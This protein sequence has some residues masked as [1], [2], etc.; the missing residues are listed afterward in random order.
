MSS[1]PPLTLES[2]RI[3]LLAAIGEVRRHLEVRLGRA[4]AAEPVEEANPKKTK[5]NAKVPAAEKAP[6]EPALQGPLALVVERFSLSPFERDVLLL[7][8]GVEFDASFAALV[9]EAQGRGGPR[10]ATFGLALSMLPNP[11]WSALAP[12]A[13]LRRWKLV[14]LANDQGL[15]SSALRIDERLLH[16]LA[17]ITYAEPRLQ[18]LVE[19]VNT[20]AELSPTQLE[21]A[22]SVVAAW[23]SNERLEEQPLVELEG[24]DP[25]GHESLIATAAGTLR[26]RMHALRAHDLPVSA[27][28]RVLLARLWERESLLMRSALVVFV[29]ADAADDVR[30]R[31]RSFATEIRGLVAVSTF[32]RLEWRGRRVL[33]LSVDRPGSSEQLALWRRQL[34][35]AAAQLNGAVDRVAAQFQLDA[36]AIRRAAQEALAQPAENVGAQLWEAC[37]RQARPVLE[38]LAQ[39]IEPMA[40]WDDLVLPPGQKHVLRTIVAQ[41]RQ[42]LRVGETWGF[43][44]QSARGFGIHALFAGPSGTG[45]TMAAEVLARELALD[46]HR[47][48]LSALVSKYVGETEK[49]LR[50]VFDAAER[51]G[52]ILLFDEADALFGKRSE[53]RDSH[54]RYANIEVSYLLQR[55]ESYRGLAVLTSNLKTALDPAFSRRLRFTVHF[56]FPDQALR[57]E[58]W[59]RAFPKDTPTEALDFNKLSRL[60]L[61]GGHIRNLALNAAFL[62]A[63]EN[64][65]VGMRHLLAA[66]QVEYAKLERPLTEG[67]IA[68]WV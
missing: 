39:R 18:S 19:P 41:V 3:A 15:T 8:A 17:G 60:S 61:S 46:L 34:G 47:I 16:F 27:D 7:C 55:I 21:A 31:A 32:Q 44:R 12:T 38:G 22:R 68:G 48:D 33:S 26:V 57:L 45:K 11:H 10:C 54:D 37:R 25:A 1:P 9:A 52:S 65:V 28:D 23:A 66:A 14:E 59:R 4:P 5:K 6:T 63:D 29:A 49:N 43:A 30:D 2:N 58:I 20:A 50:R 36:T 67:E 13:A 62:A 35:P 51:G 56:P 24:D 40:A 42:R 64:G 53:V